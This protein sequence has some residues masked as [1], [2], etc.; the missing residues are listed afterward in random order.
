[1]RDYR[2]LRTFR[3]ADQ[4]VTAIYRNTTGFPAGERYGLQAQLRRAAVSVPTNIVEGSARA[5][6]REYV[7]F[8]RIAFA[9]AV[10]AA[11]LVTVAERLGLWPE[12]TSSDLAAQYDELVRRL[13][14]QIEAL[15]ALSRSEHE[16]RALSREP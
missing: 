16:G 10:E 14:V 9:S 2:K 6:S 1:M 5:T 4:L 8:L 15:Q 3:L 11:Y 12:S 7:Q 13:R